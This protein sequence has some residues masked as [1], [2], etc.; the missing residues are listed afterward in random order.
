[1]GKMEQ[2]SNRSKEKLTNS[3]KSHMEKVEFLPESAKNHFRKA[4]YFMRKP[5]QAEK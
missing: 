5:A 3:Q 4:P 1:M 2:K